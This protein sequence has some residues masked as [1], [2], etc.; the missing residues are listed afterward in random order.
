[1][2]PLEPNILIICIAFGSKILVWTAKIILAIILQRYFV[3]ITILGLQKFECPPVIHNLLYMQ[4]DK[5][6]QMLQLLQG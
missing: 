4:W 6:F 2:S 5:L 1:M 3:K